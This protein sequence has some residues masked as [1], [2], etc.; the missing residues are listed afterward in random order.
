MI[1]H[2]LEQRLKTNGL[3]EAS[4]IDF[5][6][7]GSKVLEQLSTEHQENYLV[8]IQ[9]SDMAHHTIIGARCSIIKSNNVD[10]GKLQSDALLNNLRKQGFAIRKREMTNLSPTVEF[11]QFSDATE[12]WVKSFRTF[13]AL[14]STLGF[15]VSNA[16]DK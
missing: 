16:K 8:G 5:R 1:I 15:L 4:G 2:T 11:V 6:G 10:H 13:V 3:I 12:V 7:A 9:S 14:V